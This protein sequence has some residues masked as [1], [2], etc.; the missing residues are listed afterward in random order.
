[1]RAQF[2]I[3]PANQVKIGAARSG[4]IGALFQI[5]FVRS[6]SSVLIT[7]GG[8]WK[9]PDGAMRRAAVPIPL[10]WPRQFQY[11][12]NSAPRRAGKEAPFYNSDRARVDFG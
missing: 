8:P 7:A 12:R 6:Q 3:R 1:M 11:L 10:M 5:C 2:A 9:F 4:A